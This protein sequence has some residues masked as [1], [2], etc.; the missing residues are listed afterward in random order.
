MREFSGSLRPLSR[1]SLTYLQEAPVGPRRAASWQLWNQE[2]TGALDFIVS[3]KLP[4]KLWKMAAK[5]LIHGLI[6][7]V[8]GRK[9]VQAREK[10]RRE[11]GW[12]KSVSASTQDIIHLYSHVHPMQN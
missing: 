11:I 6:K 1:R 2:E 12:R 9:K 7:R 3:T 10:E 4:K 8:N 5:S